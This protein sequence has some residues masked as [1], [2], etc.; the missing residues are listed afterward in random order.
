MGRFT[1]SKWRIRFSEILEKIV[2]VSAFHSSVAKWRKMF[3]N[4][5]ALRRICFYVAELFKPTLAKFMKS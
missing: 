2:V 5:S 3:K 1:W 4:V